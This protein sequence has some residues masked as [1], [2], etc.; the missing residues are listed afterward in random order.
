MLIGVK[1]LKPLGDLNVALFEQYPLLVP[2]LS[3]KHLGVQG[4]KIRKNLFALNCQPLLDKT[5][6]YLANWPA[7]PLSL[8][9]RIDTIKMEALS[10]VSVFFSKVYP[11]QLPNMFRETYILQ[12][13]LLSGLEV[14]L[15]LILK[16]RSFSWS[17][18]DWLLLILLLF[19]AVLVKR[20]ASRLKQFPALSG[21][22]S[23]C[24][25]VQPQTEQSQA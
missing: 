9:G 25:T 7:L 23:M 21:G 10:K 14:N 24:R 22:S 5:I 17:Q 16:L 4:D 18:L 3:F 13:V 6:S 2:P 1:L 20:V 8:I 11:I 19:L 12:L 15:R